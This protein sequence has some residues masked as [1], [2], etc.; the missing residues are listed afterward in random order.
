MSP[1]SR[2][3]LVAV[4]LLAAILSAVI[5]LP[6]QASAVFQSP[7]PPPPSHCTGFFYVVHWGDTLNR[8]AARYGVSVAEIK[9]AN[10]LVSNTIYAGQKLCIPRGHFPPPPPPPS[11]K[12][13]C[14]YVVRCGDTLSKI[15]VRYHTSV[16]ELRSMNFIPNPNVLYAGQRLRVPCDGHH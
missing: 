10:G 12:Q 8:I 4:A 3:S 5:A 11:P 9:R 15:A 6:L 7:P 2:R 16:W 14:I 13:C 1:I